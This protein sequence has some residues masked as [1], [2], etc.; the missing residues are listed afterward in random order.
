MN[1]NAS[2]YKISVDN[3]DTKTNQIVSKYPNL[4]SSSAGK[5][6]NFQARLHLNEKATPKF[7]A[8]RRVPFAL[9][10]A[11][12]RELDKQVEEGLLKKV[13]TSEW[14]TPIVPVS[15]SNGNVRI[16]GDYKITLNP[17]LHVDEHPLPTIEELFCAMAGGTKFTKIDLSKA[18]LQLEIHPDDQHLLT[19][20]T[21]KGLY[22][23]TRMM[24]GIA[25]AP[26]KWQRFMEQLLHDIPGVS[27]F[28]DDIKI[29]AE[30]DERHLQRIDEVLKR[31]DSHNM[32]VNLQKSEFLKDQIE[33]CGYLIDREGI[34]KVKSKVMAIQAMKRPSNKDEVRAF[35]GLINYYGRFVMDLST[36]LY[37]I[38][39][40]LQ[41][42]VPFVWAIDCENS[43]VEIKKQMQSDTVLT[44]Y[45]PKLPVLLAVDASPYGVG[46]VLSHEYPNGTERPI[47]FASQ[48]LSATQQKYSQIDKEAYAIVFG[49]K[50]FLQY[51]FGRMFILISD[52][53]PL[54]QI[55]AP[56]KGLPTLTATRMQHYAIFLAS[57]NYKIR[58]KK[59]KDNANADAMSR[60]PCGEECNYIEEIDCIETEL[61][62]N[63]PVTVI[64]L[65]QATSKEKEV[66]ILVESLKHGRECEAKHRFG[67]AQTEFTLQQGCLLR[68]IRV[69]IPPE[70]RKKVLS[71][72]HTA[73]FGMV[74]MKTL[75]RGYCW[76]NQMDGDIE[77]LVSN[78]G[79]CQSIR[80]E[81]L[82]VTHK[83]F[84]NTPCK[85]FERV[86]A[87]F[88][89]PFMGKYLFILVDAY[90]KW[91]EVHVIPNITASTTIQK[92]REIF[93]MFGIPNVFVSD[94]GTQFTSTEFQNFLKINGIQHKHGAPYHPAT[95]GQAERY[96]RTFKNKLKTIK[97]Q[98][99]DMQ[100]EITKILLAYRR[101]I[102]PATG[103]SPAMAMFG[104][105]IQSRLDLMLPKPDKI[106]K[107]NAPKHFTVGER[108]A[109]RDYLSNDKWQFGRILSKL[110]ELHYDIKLDDERI[111]KRHLDQIRK[112]GDQI[113]EKKDSINDQ[114]RPGT[115]A[116]TSVI[117]APGKTVE[118]TPNNDLNLRRSNRS[119][120]APQRLGITK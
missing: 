51:L 36:I 115:S 58:V 108:V 109:V 33:Y 76:W 116:S 99:G 113:P 29:T 74:K 26:A 41:N 31:L 63:L 10:E 61:I 20:N 9:K 46:A 91:P 86:H 30:S 56:T 103:K 22:Q 43:F 75:A 15:K 111:W 89:G 94:L 92:C 44:H 13:D 117:E 1:T 19:L 54:A 7:F 93:A 84:W 106:E 38:N 97:C 80:A 85:P 49:I 112:I 14:A 3:L 96:V 2:I 52:N 35:A 18:Y 68:G 105:Q 28:L 101:A 23:P 83:H 104:R 62:T 59:S 40:L 66:K 34:H 95:N 78:C 39:R 53:K 64:D 114:N 98:P 73:H 77:G 17:V 69:Y 102:H 70:L 120:K 57:F 55:F 32:R 24:F 67:I 16:C 47:Q 107:L 48:T 90:T 82:K 100:R 72:L 21:H 81:P 6:T 45:D 79:D 37:P 118:I 71:E 25:C 110:G 65:A 119:K 27:V 42:N 11:V 12:E 88:A 8:A 4:F 5:I 60:L 87:D 50:K